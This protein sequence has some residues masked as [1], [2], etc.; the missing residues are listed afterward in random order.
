[1]PI[2]FACTNCRQALAIAARKVG[3]KV[4][5]PKCQTELT[6]PAAE[7][8][9]TVAAKVAPAKR[10]NV[11]TKAPPAS[12]AAAPEAP[13][14]SA[15]QPVEGTPSFSSLTIDVA[16]PLKPS[17]SGLV[18][19]DVK[20]ALDTPP[21]TTAAE[22]TWA[23]LA[24][25]RSR[26]PELSDRAAVDRSLV[27]VSRTVLYGQAILIVVVAIAGFSIGYL[28]GRGPRQLTP[29]EL[30][31]N[32]QPVAVIGEVLYRTDAGADA[33]DLN[34]VVIAV[35]RDA[36]P[37]QKF[38]IAGLRPSDP[39]AADGAANLSVQ[40]IES[41]GGGYSRADVGGQFRINV[42]PGKYW[43]LV[44][45]ANAARP[46]GVL[47]TTRDVRTLGRYFDVA[48]DLLADRRYAL[49]EQQLPSEDPLEFALD[50]K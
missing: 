45:S 14:S 49:V 4:K 25:T 35:S 13:T 39:P 3:S 2:R 9:V 12:T 37:G 11:E 18:F 42:R 36:S 27:A 41:E 22:P 50:P 33:P 40:A 10:A 7:R 6:V 24:D 34:A 31:A 28:S 8:P 44:I 43:L 20:A 47:P 46:A 48:A 5:C 19:D 26:S 38:S 29:E 32:Q 21:M 16:A 23:S 1:M 30:A 17:F 15:K